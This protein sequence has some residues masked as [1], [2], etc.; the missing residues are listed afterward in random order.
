[1]TSPA[2]SLELC[3]FSAA[4]GCFLLAPAHSDCS[5]ANQSLCA[6][7]ATTSHL[8]AR[9]FVDLQSWD[10]LLRRA[11]TCQR[12]PT[13]R[14]RKLMATDWRR[15]DGAAGWQREMQKN[16]RACEDWLN[17]AFRQLPMRQQHEFL[18]D[19]LYAAMKRQRAAAL[20]DSKRARNLQQ[21]FS[22]AEMVQLVVASVLEYVAV[23]AVAWLEP[24]CGDGRFLTAL[25]RAG[26]QHVVGYE[27]DQRLQSL[28]ERNVQRAAVDV[29]GISMTCSG[30]G[31]SRVHAQVCL[32]DFLTSKSCVP[33]DNFVV[34]IGN[35]PFG[36]RG[37]SRNDLVHDF[38]RHA[39]SAWR[40]RVI[41]FIVPERCSRPLF[42]EQTLQKLNSERV[43]SNAATALSCWILAMELP[44][45]DYEF[46]FGAH[47]VPKRVRQPSLLQLFTCAR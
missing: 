36:A 47:D 45:T 19:E 3:G 42:V 39:A 41:A 2:T 43:D 7:C 6:P 20:A 21:Y 31:S 16:V 23:R 44:L 30:E 24:S 37:E 29:A 11:S 26:A 12:L 28:A 38:F 22:S 9:E 18:D 34:A 33:A 27:I 15:G 40:A 25:L 14:L 8:L 10:R 46:E 17:A 1:M 5:R 4:R 13:K 35:P 32:G